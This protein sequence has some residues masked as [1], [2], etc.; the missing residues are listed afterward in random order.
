VFALTVRFIAPERSNRLLPA[1][2]FTVKSLHCFA[3]V[4]VTVMLVCRN[5]LQSSVSVGFVPDAKVGVNSSLYLR[6]G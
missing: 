6:P 1:V 2:P 4:G 5:C 3:L